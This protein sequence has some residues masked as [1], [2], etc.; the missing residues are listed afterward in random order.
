[1][2]LNIRQ[3]EARLPIEP[4]SGFI[5]LTNLIWGQKRKRKR[6]KKGGKRGKTG[7]E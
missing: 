2:G 6:K 1:M 3:F 4:L 7:C 5:V